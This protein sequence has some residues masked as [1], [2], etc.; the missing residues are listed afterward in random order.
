MISY[1]KSGLVA[2]LALGAATLALAQSTPPSGGTSPSDSSPP[3]SQTSPDSMSSGSDSSMSPA[4]NKLD[5]KTKQ[6]IAS[7]KAKNSG[8]SENQ[9]KQKCMM[10]IGSHQGQGQDQGH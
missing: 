8:Q 2:V 3:S 6:C 5:A 9:I 10:Q 7:E 4:S 1:R